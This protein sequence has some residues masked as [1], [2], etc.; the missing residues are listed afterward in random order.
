MWSDALVPFGHLFSS[1]ENGYL[2]PLPFKSD[3]L[4]GFSIEW[5]IYVFGY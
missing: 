2:V 3:Y 1:L 4:G 5:V